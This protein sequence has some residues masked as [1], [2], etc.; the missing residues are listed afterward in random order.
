MLSVYPPHDARSRQRMERVRM[1]ELEQIKWDQEALVMIDAMNQALFL[2]FKDV[3]TEFC[4][5][6]GLSWERYPDRRICACP[7]HNGQRAKPGG[8]RR[9]SGPG[10]WFAKKQLNRPPLVA[11]RPPPSP[12]CSPPPPP[13][14]PPVLK[15]PV[16]MSKP[17]PPPPVSKLRSKPQPPL[18]ASAPAP[19]PQRRARAGSMSQPAPKPASPPPP[20][21][22]PVAP[23][24]EQPSTQGPQTRARAGSV[25][26]GSSRGRS[27]S[28]SSRASIETIRP[29]RTQEKFFITEEDEEAD[30]EEEGD[31][32]MTPVASP[33]VR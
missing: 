9:C 23:V 4:D 33:R 8:V 13:P 31:G 28:V 11:L 20:V 15:L 27:V 1:L 3:K 26:R 21:P 14:K 30:E 19:G 24:I 7:A 12:P 18:P 22:V 16:V 32:E 10:S 17:P 2:S 25:S 5:L 29:S 6:D